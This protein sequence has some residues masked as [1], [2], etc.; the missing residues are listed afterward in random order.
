MKA[1]SMI[2]GALLFGLG[3][4]VGLTLD[5]FTT[6]TG[7]RPSSVQILGLLLAGIFAGFTIILLKARED[8]HGPEEET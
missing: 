2:A 5:H 7:P 4:V 1:G 3:I 6:W 8:P